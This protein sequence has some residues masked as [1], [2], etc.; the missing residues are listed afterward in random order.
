M[1]C[2]PDSNG[3]LS[4]AERTVTREA[5]G[6]GGEKRA[7]TE[8]YSTYV[9]GLTGDGSLQLVKREDT[10]QRTGA[11]GQQSTTRQVE[12]VNP[13]DPS[14]GLQVAEQATDIVRTRQQRRGARTDDGIGRGSGWPDACGVGGYGKERQAGCGAGRYEQE[15]QGEVTQAGGLKADG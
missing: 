11:D 2:R 7:T 12:Q 9:P 3:A 1:C 8:T 15:T 6:S 5:P 10:V 4:V 13:G 14:S